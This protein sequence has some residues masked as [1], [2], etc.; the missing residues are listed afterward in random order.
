MTITLNHLLRK[1]KL[2][3]SKSI[4]LFLL[5]L[6]ISST[7]IN[8][9]AQVTVSPNVRSYSTL[10]LAFDAIN[11]GTH[12]GTITVTI[13]A[14]T[15]ESAS[16]VLNASGVGSA[17]YTSINIYPTGSGLTISGNLSTPLIDLNGADN[18]IIDG[19]VNATGNA[20]DLTITNTNTTNTASTIR[21]INSATSN[22]VK[23]CTIKGSTTQPNSITAVNGI[24]T[25]STAGTGNGNDDNV[26]SN[27]KIT[28]AGTR[29]QSAIFASGTI[30]KENSGVIIRENNIYDI[31]HTGNKGINGSII[32]IYTANTDFQ[33]TA[34]SLY[35][36]TSW[37][38]GNTSFT[39]ININ[40]ASGNNFTVSN[41]YIGGSLPLCAGTAWT[42]L[43]NGRDNFDCIYM[44]VGSTT[45][46]NIHGNTIS[47]WNYNESNNT[48]IWSGITFIGGSA[49]IGTISGN[50][51]GSGSG[52]G[53]ITVYNSSIVYGI[54][55]GGG[56]I[57]NIKNNIIGSITNTTASFTQGIFASVSGTLT[58]E[59]NTIGSTT[60]ANSIYAS[61]TSNQG[62]WAINVNSSTG[63]TIIKGN[64]IANVSSNST[65][66]NDLKGISYSGGLNTANIYGNFIRNI[67]YV[68]ASSIGKLTGIDLVAGNNS[69]YNNIISLG[70]NRPALIYGITTTGGTNNIYFNTVYLTGIPTSGSLNSAAL[71]S[72]AANTRDI[73]NNIF[74][75]SRTN[76]GA[77]GKHF[78]TYFGAAGTG[79]TIDYNDYYVSGSGGLLGFYNSTSVN[80]LSDWKTATGQDVN[81]L[82]ADPTFSNAGGTNSTDYYINATLTG[83]SGTGIT[84]DYNDIPRH[85]STPRIGAW[86]V[87]GQLKTWTGNTSNSW[88]TSTNWSPSVVPA[89]SDFLLINS[90]TPQLDVDFSVANRLIIANT[91]TLIIN[92]GKTL[93]ITSAGTADF[94]GKLVTLKSDA[95]GTASLGNIAGT[96][97]NA[98]NVSVERFIP[99]RRAFRFLSSPV[100]T[101]NFI[102]GNW[103]QATHIT[104]SVTGQN[105]FDPS[106]TGSASVFTYNISGEAWAAIQNTNA[107]NLTIG[108]GYRLLIRGDRNIN[109]NTTT[110]QDSAAL[111]LKATGS[112]I[113]GNVVFGAGSVSSSPAG[114]PALNAAAG[115][116]SNNSTVGWSLIGNPYASAVNW[117]NVTKSNV[118]TTFATW[119]VNNAGRGSYVYHDGSTGTG[120]GNSNIINSGQAIFVQTTGANPSITFTEA[121]K[122][123]STPPSHFKK[124]IADVLNID[125]F[126]GDRAYDALTV[127]FDANNSNAY[128]VNDFIKLVN[129]EINFY[130]YLADGTKLAMNNMQEIKEETVVSL[131]LNG[132]FNGGTYDLKFSN[133]N[134][135]ANAEVKLKDKFINKVYDLKSINN[136]TFTVTTDSNSFGE[137]RFELIFSKS[138]TGLNN[139]LSLN[140]NFMVFPNPANNILNLSLTN[141]QE[142]NYSFSI[143]NQLGAEVNAGNLDFNS[144][145]TQALN[146]ENLSNGV[147]FIQVKNA[148]S[149]QTIKFIK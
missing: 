14:N 141:T 57:L 142:D 133:Q 108:T 83:V 27:N 131:G 138:A 101:A 130:S 132:V 89:S 103:Q 30:G 119:N 112:I 38:P 72:S 78:A 49:N 33:I 47:N 74:F 88:N 116:G 125:I 39:G 104:G 54:N 44:N 124:S 53:A 2:L 121:S 102:A 117:A 22:I 13:T 23:Y 73:R 56:G 144:K 58:I 93:S 16:A 110:P 95:T 24:I 135:F 8:A 134:S 11:S 25:I 122:V 63:T 71:F 36:T 145:R 94:G 62:V 111:V 86:E 1:K 140:N 77:T 70:N 115:S 5:T 41:N 60:S 68:N 92:A 96:L 97:S 7:I 42:K 90:G 46:S 59:N 114:I 65:I 61:H 99:R 40:N 45:A 128:D 91:G 107:T 52:T 9:N 75:N 3:K 32:F 118:S 87:T 6:L 137:N 67:N 29:L 76:S 10:K 129:P 143:F 31:L 43:S 12:T 21:F 18:V 35:E 147:Y 15:S 4:K 28:N 98:T 69:T 123:T 20:G 146:I 127:L 149:A 55:L 100:N 120:F 51:I 81:S 84:T 105:G 139:A 113:T 80:T 48:R 66:N 34:N 19:R 148:K 109:L 79:L 82:N 136:L 17:N 37:S 26:I 50:I 126:I 106:P 85:V 64:T